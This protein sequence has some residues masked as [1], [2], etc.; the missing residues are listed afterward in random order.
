MTFSGGNAA[1]I[2]NADV[3]QLF[4]DTVIQ[5]ED[6]LNITK[7]AHTMHMGFQGWRQRIDTFYSGNNGLAGTFTFDGRYTAGPNPLATSGGGT[8]H[9]EA[10]F[11]LGC[12]RISAPA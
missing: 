8:G 5:Y 4:A 10:D 6:T 12:R 11:L 7:G 3:Y 1:T 9:A 2:G